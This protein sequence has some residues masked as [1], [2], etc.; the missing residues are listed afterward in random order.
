MTK[1]PK[2]DKALRGA[3]DK[4]KLI[5]M[6]VDITT[7]LSDGPNNNCFRTTNLQDTLLIYSDPSTLSRG[8]PLNLALAVSLAGLENTFELAGVFDLFMNSPNYDNLLHTSL[9]FK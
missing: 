5:R 3:E 9:I 8:Y 2:K 7:N 1:L 4:R 6:A